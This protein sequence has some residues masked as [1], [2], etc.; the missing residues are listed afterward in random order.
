M[1]FIVEVLLLTS[2]DLI[3][4]LIVIAKVVGMC[5]YENSI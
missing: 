3:A 2:K 1:E 5:P 4:V